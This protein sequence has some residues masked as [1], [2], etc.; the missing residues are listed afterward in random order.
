MLASNSNSD[1]SVLKHAR[2]KSTYHNLPPKLFEFALKVYEGEDLKKI[3]FEQEKLQ[4]EK[5]YEFMSEIN[6]KIDELFACFNY[7][8]QVKPPQLT[9]IENSK[10]ERPKFISDD[11]IEE[12]VSGKLRI[13]FKTK[14]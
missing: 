3:V 12:E 1:M 8:F 6:S 7:R 4:L 13:K 5:T 9:K 10:L 11:Y 2:I 14:S